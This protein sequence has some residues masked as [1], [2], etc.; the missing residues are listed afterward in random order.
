MER[1]KT[2]PTYCVVIEWDNARFSELSRARRMLAELLRQMEAL[3][4]RTGGLGRVIVVYDES[5]IDVRLLRQCFFEYAGNAWDEK[6]RFVTR[7]GARY[8]ELK[9]LGA[10]EASGDVLVFLDSDVIPEPGWLMSLL[11][12][13]QDPNVEVVSGGTFISLD[14]LYEK[15]FALFWFFPLRRSAP[16][17]RE[18]RN[19]FA[20]NVAFRRQVFARHPFP[21]LVQS[22]GQCVALAETLVKQRIGLYR[23][24]SAWVSHPPPN[25]IQHFCMR[26]VT[27]GH[28]RLAD[29]CRSADGIAPPLRTTYWAFVANLRFALWR[30]RTHFREV[31]LGRAGAAYAALL[32]ALYYSIMAGG[33]MLTR[34]SPGFVRRHLLV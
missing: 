6:I 30:I 7:P 23:Q 29:V 13:F 11:G 28:D 3:A 34:A 17:L 16:T 10:K 15:A 4:V 22:R 25:G 19:F 24:E 1:P 18:A 14:G 2:T 27:Q 20:N 33:E 9:N 31:G 26:A 8:Y 12:S 5:R 21:E 32:A